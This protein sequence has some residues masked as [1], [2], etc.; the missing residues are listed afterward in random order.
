[1]KVGDLVKWDWCLNEINSFQ[2]EFSGV[3]V[4]S[5]FFKNG[6]SQVEVF[7]VFTNDNEVINIRKDDPSLKLVK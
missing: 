7:T 3:I 2:S 1:M 6:S 5:S 4:N